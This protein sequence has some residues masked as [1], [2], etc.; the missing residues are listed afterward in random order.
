MLSAERHQRILDFLLQR[1]SASVAELSEELGASASTIGRDLS[2]LAAEG[3]LQRVRGGASLSSGLHPDLPSKLER[4]RNVREKEA[5][6][7]AAAAM[8]E[9]GEVVFLEASTTVRHVA[10]HLRNMRNLTVVT[11]DVYI[12]SELADSPG[13]E[14]I[15]TGGTLR[16]ATQALIGPLV[17]RV[18]EIIHVDKVFTG[19]SGIHVDHGLSTGNLTEGQAKQRLLTTGDRIIGVCDHT[20][21]GRVAFCRLGPVNALDVL[22]TD[23]LAPAADIARIRE[24]GTEVVAAPIDGRFDLESIA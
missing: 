12:A 1:R 16:A 13:I 15:V 6:G 9:P 8:V 3:L 14:T 4:L 21:F 5:I 11:N 22:V 24:L 17:E 7:L 18:L 19:I 20:K 2:V 10:R 23:C